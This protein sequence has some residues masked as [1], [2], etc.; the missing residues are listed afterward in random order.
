MNKNLKKVGDWLALNQLSVNVNK[1]TFM[2]F[3][4]YKNSV[5]KNISIKLNNSN[6]KRVVSTKYL[7]ITF[8]FY[9]KWKTHIKL[10]LKKSRYLLYFIK[11]LSK[12][13]SSK[14]LLIIYYALFY[15]NISYGIAAWGGAYANVIDSLQNL[16]DRILK[17]VI[18]DN[19]TVLRPL[20]LYKSFKLHSL[21][22]YYQEYKNRY[23]NSNR[24]MRKK[25]LRLPKI[26]K[27]ISFKN[28]KIVAIKF[29]NTLPKEL[30]TLSF[31]NKINL[32]NKLKKCFY[33]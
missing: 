7:G 29:Y 27:S 2:T 17:V 31:N 25:S 3:G 32:K 18:K 1:T 6:I 10:I 24:L 15:S 4:I 26:H 23:E 21:L 28:S 20:N 19:N 5:P 12:T 16:Q 13:M 33:K 11:K 9:M 14:V 22:L 30:K 8:D